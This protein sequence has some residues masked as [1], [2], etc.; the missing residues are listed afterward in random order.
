[1]DARNV[2]ILPP[3]PDEAFPNDTIYIDD[4]ARLA[5][6][7]NWGDKIKLIG[8]KECEAKIAELRSYDQGAQICRMNDKLMDDIFSVIGDQ[9]LLYKLD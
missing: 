4:S 6:H 8:R 9:L 7:A 1:M 2:K 5:L 3:Y